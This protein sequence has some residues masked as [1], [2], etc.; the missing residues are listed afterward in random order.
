MPC[1][2]TEDGECVCDPEPIC[3]VAPTCA[4]PSE[5][6]LPDWKPL[7]Q[8]PDAQYTMGPDNGTNLTGPAAD[9]AAREAKCSL[10]SKGSEAAYVKC[11]SGWAEEPDDPHPLHEEHD[12]VFV[13]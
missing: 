5:C 12:P 10:E 4:R 2:T 9:E 13:P 6:G 1:Y 8:P 7:W 3:P 11:M